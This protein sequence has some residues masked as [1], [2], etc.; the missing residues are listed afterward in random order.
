MLQLASCY[1][2]TTIPASLLNP[3]SLTGLLTAP[4]DTLLATRGRATE[5]L[6]ELNDTG[7]L[8]ATEGGFALHTAI[9][10]AGRA[11]LSG[12]DPHSAR[13]WH[14]AIR[15]LADSTAK[16]PVD[17]PQSWP[18][19]LLLGPH[20]LSLLQATAGRVDQEHLTLLMETAARILDAF[21]QIK[22]S[23][24]VCV[25]GEHA[26]TCGAALRDEH[27][28]VLRVRHCL[29][30]AIADRGDLD[31]AEAMYR[32]VYQIRLRALGASDQDVLDSR[33]ELAWI[34]ACRQDWATAERGYRET[35]E[36]SVRLRNPDDPRTMLTRHELAWAIANQGPNRLGE[37]REI[38]GTV[39]ADRC[40]ILGAE[41]HRTL[42]TL[43]E[44]AW[45]TAQQGKWKDAEAA[46]Q[47]VLALR[48]RI[49][50]KD[51]PDTILTRHEMAWVTA[52][53]GR[54]R[55]AESRY[56]DVLSHSRRILG[57]DHPRTLATQE[58]LEELRCGRIIDA[59]HLA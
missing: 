10:E 13:I 30:W 17:Q 36:D 43:H 33:H 41:H 35:L 16:L 20:L 51:H 28:A 26:L 1:A 53:R 3:T 48:L 27:R 6:R 58:A 7:I 55:E 5:A 9:S 34:A 52:R 40:R 50:G 38:F 47:E 56:S 18:Q 31:K 24:V 25:L 8:E 14:C 2:A 49:L 4:G 22:A 45:I 21:N 39:L 46:Y 57:E 19:Y 15:L 12:P 44:L 11:S 59:R 54:V 42:T 29:A 23:Q 32:D 37:A